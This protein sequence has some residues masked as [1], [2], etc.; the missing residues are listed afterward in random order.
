VRVLIL[1]GTVFLGR[2]A[3]EAAVG[4]GHE[5]SLFHRGR[6]SDAPEGCEEL[7]GDRN[8]DVSAL[9]GREWDAV[10]DTS[11]YL[12]EQVA[13]ATDA[14]ATGHYTLV[15]S[16]SAYAD[17]SRPGLTEDDPVAEPS[18]EGRALD[19]ESYGP[20]KVACERAARAAIPSA[21]VVRPGL[22][23]G[24]LDPTDRFTYWPRRAARGG[25]MLVPGRPERAVQMIDARDLAA[26]LL[27]L[28][29]RGATG[30]FNATGRPLQMGELVDACVEASGGDARPVWAPEAFLVERGVEPW[31]ELPLWIPEDDPDEPGFMRM[32]V[33]RALAEGLRLRPLVQ[34]ARDTLAWDRARSGPVG[35][36]A[37]YG[38]VPEPAG[39]SEERERELLAELRG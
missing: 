35:P 2:H 30:T 4:R 34:T 27:D 9:S 39:M 8:G 10:I 17:F 38:L 14:I 32:D 20:L 3:A 33:S 28:A 37:P 22:I 26:W 18:E 1:G 25:D 31:S 29:E 11:A 6:N 19:E 16:I 15:S 24:P 36:E 7:L 5:V 23:V 12:P 21:L 13:R